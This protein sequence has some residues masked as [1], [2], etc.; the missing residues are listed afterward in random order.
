MDEYKE[1]GLEFRHHDTQISAANRLMLPPLVIGLLVL[2][3]EVDKFLGVEFKNPEAVYQLVWVGCLIISLIW[4]F[5][6]SRTAQLVHSHLDTR[7]KN[8]EIF[9]LRGHTKIFIMDKDSG[10]SK[11]FRHNKLRLVGFGIY[12]SLLL[13]FPLK[14]IVSYNAF[15]PRVAIIVSGIL[16][17]WIWY[18]YFKQPFRTSNKTPIRWQHV[19]SIILL[20]IPLALPFLAKVTQTAIHDIV[21]WVVIE[22]V[23][24]W[25][26]FL[27]WHFYFKKCSPSTSKNSLKWYHI[28]LIIIFLILI[29]DPLTFF[30]ADLQTQPDANAH[31]MQG[32]KHYEKGEY[33]EAIEEYTKAITIK[34]NYAK[35]YALRGEAYRAQG[36]D[37]KSDRDL[38]LA[39][40]LREG[41]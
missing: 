25:L 24:A 9:G 15:I 2:Y 21:L 31:L 14:S 3:G 26:L 5:N 30:L 40:A 29:I 22:A 4:V 10:F 18:F 12:F 13:N 8:A 20:L 35:V 27:I 39:K 33:A 11:I 28:A 41:Q 7:R 37:E 17:I 6:V 1:A 19:V 38:K 34:L 16:S 23:V 32:L 36:E